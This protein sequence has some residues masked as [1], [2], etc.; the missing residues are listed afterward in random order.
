MNPPLCCPECNG[1]LTNSTTALV[2][3][4]CNH[5]FKVINGIPHFIDYSDE[6]NKHQWEEVFNE[7]AFTKTYNSLKK[8]I[9]SEYH[10]VNHIADF[11]GD[12]KA[13]AT[14]VELGSG[15]RKLTESIVNVD[16][17]PFKNVGVVADITKTPFTDES[18]DY[19]IIDTVLE[20]VKEPHT[21]V[22]EIYRVL[23]PGG[24]VL[25]IVPFIFPYHGYPKNYFNF[26]ADALELLFAKFSKCEICFD[27][28]P[29]SALINL[30]SEYLSLAFS[31][32]RTSYIIFKGLFLL[33]LFILKYLDKFWAVNGNAV[34][35]SSTLCAYV[36]K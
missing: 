4:Q 22:A 11:I 1:N 31:K 24:K 12:I 16:L 7:T 32:N 20:H 13:G 26:S 19:I 2:C 25:C 17:F 8:I 18:I 29:T 15:S 33:P 9:S 5:V 21:V 6:I 3:G 28:G 30:V 27:M 10:K 14:V 34:R 23:K 35:I 36:V